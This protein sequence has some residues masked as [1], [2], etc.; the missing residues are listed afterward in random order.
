MFTARSAWSQLEPREEVEKTLRSNAKKKR[1]FCGNSKGT[2]QRV[3][4]LDPEPYRGSDAVHP[5][6]LPPLPFYHAVRPHSSGRGVDLIVGQGNANSCPGQDCHPVW[7]YRVCTSICQWLMNMVNNRI[8]FQVVR[9]IRVQ[10]FQHM[11][12]LP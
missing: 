8:T 10:A 7:R 11:E 3:L 6:C 9:D 2:I 1:V 12:I 5:C 4:K